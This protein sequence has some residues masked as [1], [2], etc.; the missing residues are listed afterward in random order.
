MQCRHAEAGRVSGGAGVESAAPRRTAL[1]VVR[2]LDAVSVGGHR[3]AAP[4]AS[5]RA[6]LPHSGR[7]E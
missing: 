3:A 4:A 5:R 1:G 2:Q 6:G 7:A